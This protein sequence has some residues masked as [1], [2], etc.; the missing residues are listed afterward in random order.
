MRHRPLKFTPALGA[1]MLVA[2]AGPAAA[3]TKS[4]CTAVLD[5]LY[6]QTLSVQLIGRN[7]DKDEQSL[8]GKAGEAKAKLAID[9][10]ADAI[11]KLRDFQSKLTQ[12]SFDPTS[13]AGYTFSDYLKAS[14]DGIDCISKIGQ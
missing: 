14:G 4:E 13:P 11:R 12:V 7:A 6:N 9:K 10:Y 1:L 5:G 3:T 2:L 8:Q